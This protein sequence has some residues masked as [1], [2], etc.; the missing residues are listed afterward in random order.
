MAGRIER[1]VD[2]LAWWQD[3]QV[4]VAVRAGGLHGLPHR[5]LGPWNEEDLVDVRVDQVGVQ[6][7]ALRHADELAA[8]N[9]SEPVRS[10]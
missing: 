4:A 9:E 10:E 7:P 8:E 6:A 3:K 1:A 2:A 5:V